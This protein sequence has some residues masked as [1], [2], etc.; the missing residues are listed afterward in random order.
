[1]SVYEVH[2]GSWL[3]APAHGPDGGP[4]VQAGAWHPPRFLNYRDIAPRLATYVAELG[5]THVELL[6]VM[7][8]PFYGSWGYQITGY[9][10]PTA[11]YGT[12]RSASGTSR[13]MT[14]ALNTTAERIALEGVARP[15]TFSRL[16]T[17]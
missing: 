15:M 7:E 4:P 3:Q 1:M 14:M 12:P 2:L 17:G 10:S 5:F 16:S 9:F 8:H 6:P 11:R 13:M